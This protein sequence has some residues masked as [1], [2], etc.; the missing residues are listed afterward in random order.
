MKELDF[1]AKIWESKYYLG[2]FSD[3]INKNRYFERSS[4]DLSQL[5]ELED[6]NL[7]IDKSF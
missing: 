5:N 1:F 6:C 3:L 7:N 2:E 4:L